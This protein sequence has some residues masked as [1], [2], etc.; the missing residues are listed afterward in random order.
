MRS[1]DPSNE[2]ESAPSPDVVA[3]LAR[4]HAAFVDFVQR[5]VG[6]RD[7]AEEIVQAALV[8]NLEKV[9]DIRESAVAWFYAV[10]RNAIIDHR[11][12]LATA[13]KRLESY[14]ADAQLSTATDEELQRVVCQCV[15]ELASTLKPEYADALR[16][17][18]LEG[19]SVKDYA[20]RSGISANNAA[21]RV[22][23]AREALHK[24]VV[25]CCGTCATHGCFD[26]SCSSA[27]PARQPEV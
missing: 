26:C 23:R 10:L 13:E 8:R 15:G 12:R 27:P 1:E 2:P 18:E 24:Q 5:R 25:R 9:Q 19:V 7:V 16:Q 3:T 4:N 17:I 20:E 21:V 22:F 14:A 11:R 6:D